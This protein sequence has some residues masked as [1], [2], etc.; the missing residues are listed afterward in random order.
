MHD[1]KH[2]DL[3]STRY[4]GKMRSFVHDP[5]H[6]DL[7]STRHNGKMRSFVHDPKH[8]DRTA[9]V[10]TRYNGKMRSGEPVPIANG[11]SFLVNENSL[12]VFTY[13]VIY[14]L[15]QG[16]HRPS[17]TELTLQRILDVLILEKAGIDFR[18]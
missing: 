9:L 1:P 15:I 4:N 18:N 3:Y 10:N 16:K 8:V 13:P 6:V 5:K 12:V 17:C 11:F 7:Y 2:V 14:K